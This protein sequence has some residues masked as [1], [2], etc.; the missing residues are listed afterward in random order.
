MAANIQ[1]SVD[2]VAAYEALSARDPRFDGLFFVGV[3]TTGVYCRPIC[4]ARTP[5]KDRCEFFR[6]AAEAETRGFR[7]CFRCRPE[8]APGLASVDAAPRLCARALRAIDEG[9]LNEHSL[10]ELA[11]ALSVSERHLRRQ[12]ERELGVSPVALAQSRRLSA[13]KQL[14]TDT[15]LSMAEIAFASGFRSVRRFNAAWRHSFGAAPSRAGERPMAEPGVLMLRLDYRPPFAWGELVSFLGARAIA[16]VE[17]GR[18]GVYAR[19][20][21]TPGG[22]GWLEA[23]ADQR[24]PRIE[25]RLSTS[26]AERVPWVIARVRQ[27]F[28]LDARP[29]VIASRLRRDPLLARLVRAAPG[30][31][32]PG[33]FDPFEMAVRAVL[34]QQVS[35]KAATT[36]AGRFAAKLGEPIAGAPH[37]LSALFPLPERVAALQPSVI[38]GLG[39]LEKRAHTIVGLARLFASGELARPGLSQD[40]VCARLLSLPG[41]GDWTAQYVA[42]R[43]FRFPDAFPAGDLG[44]KKALALSSTRACDARSQAWRPWR[45]Y[46]AL[47]LWHSLAQSERSPSVVDLDLYAT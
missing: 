17:I 36:L 41:V 14:L 44:I 12:M 3:T 34:G 22:G 27:L 25:L 33:A 16:G 20:V 11:G 9:F 39:V 47:H 21:R 24:R 19:T 28:D 29:D 8:L 18:G 31:R 43:A 35:V 1:P 26:L 37:G 38:V 4:P 6:R 30:R 13:A 2:P 32:V 45:A 23:R 15:R 10:A 7:A 40:D 42:M 46:A 5:R